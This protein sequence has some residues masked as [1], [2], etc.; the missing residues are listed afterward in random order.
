V[1]ATPGQ[2]ETR[3]KQDSDSNSPAASALAETAP[4]LPLIDRTPAPAPRK[5][6]ARKFVISMVLIPLLALAGTAGYRWQQLKHEGAPAG[7][8]ASIAVLPFV[9]M[10]PDTN[11]EY[12]SDGLTDELINHLAKL[13]G[14]KVAARSSAFQ[15]KG[16]NE[17]LR[18]VGRK[19]GVDNVLEGTVRKEGD[20]A[21]ITAELIKASDGF[22]LWSETYDRQIKDIFAV[23]DE[24][25][26]SATEALQIRLLG[27]DRVATPA[28][29]RT[30]N[31]AAYEAYL[32][33][34]FF[35]GRG[36]TKEGLD[37]AF[38][39]ADQAV[40]LDPN[41]APAW[42][43]R[44]SVLN[45]M[46][47]VTLV[48]SSEGFREARADAERSIALDPNLA[49]P[50]LALGIVQLFSDWDWQAAEASLKKAAELEPGS[51][52]VPRVRSYLAR[53]LGHLDEAIALFREA[54]SRDPLRSNSYPGLGHLLY[55]AGRYD[56]AEKSLQKT[57]ELD[58]QA[59]AVHS[60]RAVMLL[61]QRRPQQALAEAQQEPAEWARISSEALAYFDLGRRDDSNI[62]LSGLV[63]THADDAAFQIAEVYAY[64][65]E[66][67]K[68]FEWLDR[69]YEVRDPG[70]PE[71][72]IDP[73]LNNLRHDPRYSE[74]LKKMRLPA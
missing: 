40:K 72:K 62:S 17:D 46:A 37:K 59:A 32:Q 54:I 48:D 12:F 45:T 44:A 67:D 42:A 41:Y 55:C 18:L 15:F 39:Y 56:E 64:R 5:P 74:F 50:Y 65:G 21:R 6:R 71:V 33:G 27:T 13:P 52:E 4:V 47:L 61:A 51:A 19:L 29:L 68:A 66:L 26:R 63:A 31:P 30:T 38:A 36:Q 73:L 1:I 7:G 25:A 20:H 53:T 58:P 43:L 14:V 8:T 16:K 10:S 2:V 3:P 9:N 70:T 28:Q 11:D 22:Q 60:T 57:L 69:A 24:I 23:Q 49:S 34:Q 35:G